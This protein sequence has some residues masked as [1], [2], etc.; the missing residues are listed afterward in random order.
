MPGIIA[1]NESNTKWHRGGTCHFYICSPQY[2][3]LLKD[4]GKKVQYVCHKIWCIKGGQHE[5][6]TISR[7]CDCPGKLNEL[8]PIFDHY[9]LLFGDF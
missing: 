9:D 2:E 6:R 8:K 4:Q 7:V 3:D 1:T 5:V